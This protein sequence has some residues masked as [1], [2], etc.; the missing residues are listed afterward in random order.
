MRYAK[1]CA[2]AYTEML[3]VPLCYWHYKAYFIYKEV[4]N[5]VLYVWVICRIGLLLI[6]RRKSINEVRDSFKWE[7][8]ISVSAIKFLWNVMEISTLI[9][10]FFRF[11][12]K[13]IGPLLSTCFYRMAYIL[14]YC[15]YEW[16]WNIVNS[17]EEGIFV[18]IFLFLTLVTLREGKPSAKHQLIVNNLFILVLSKL[19]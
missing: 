15:S 13:L 1:V 5:N 19:T 17:K 18:Y 10:I 6:S 12:R 8:I 3:C 11:C 16:K 14:L 7:F 4:E 2:S 9:Y